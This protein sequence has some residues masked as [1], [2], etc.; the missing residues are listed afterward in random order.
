MGQGPLVSIAI[1][2]VA[3]RLPSHTEP[4]A[5]STVQVKGQPSKLRR[6]DFVGAFGLALAIVSLLGALSL[7]GQD[8]PWSHPYVIIPGAISVVAA[9]FFVIWETKYALEPVLPPSLIVQRDVATSF[10]VSA[11]QLGAQ[12][13]VCSLPLMS[14]SK[15]G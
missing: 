3:F 9:V 5:A 1:L 2:L 11:F 15:L 10:A 12:S 8:Y 6:V 4:A 7:G 14:D 13:S